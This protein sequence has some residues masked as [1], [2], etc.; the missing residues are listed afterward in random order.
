[1]QDDA[2]SIR[3]DLESPDE[4]VR[5]KAARRACPCHGSFDL[6]RELGPDLRFAARNDPSPKVRREAKHV[7]RDA[8]VVNLQ[9]DERE[10]RLDRRR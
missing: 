4:R 3:R 5:A 1:M 6:L 2:A 7:L 9:D 10:R 8:F